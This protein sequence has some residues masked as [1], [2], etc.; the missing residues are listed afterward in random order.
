MWVSRLHLSLTSIP[1]L[2]IAFASSKLLW[3]EYKSPLQREQD[4]QLISNILFKPVA[5]APRTFRGQ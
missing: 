1:N 4:V 5:V 3:L 2:D